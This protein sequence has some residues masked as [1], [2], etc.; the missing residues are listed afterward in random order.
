MR[1]ILI[2]SILS[3]FFIIV[4]SPSTFAASAQGEMSVT[5]LDLKSLSFEEVMEIC[6]DTPEALQ[7]DVYR[8][9]IEQETRSA[10]N[11]VIGVA[12]YSYPVYNTNFE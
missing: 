12:T 1:K 6:E 9:R 3:A 11:R 7:C 10:D 2:G 4:L 8:D 5:I